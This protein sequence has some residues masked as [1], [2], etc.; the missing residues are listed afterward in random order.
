[1]NI[2]VVDDDA[3]ILQLVKIHLSKEGYKVL[4]AENAEQAFDLLDHMKPD[5]AIVD[6]MMPGMNG[7]E[8]TKIL[9]K[10]YGIP[11]LL[12]TAKGELED[13]E[14]G[15]LAGADDYV[16]R[17]FEPKELLFRVRVILRRSHKEFSSIIQVGNLTVNRTTF[18]ISTGTQSAVIPLKEFE[19]LALLASKAGYV[20]ERGNIMEQIW[21]FDYQGD[22]HTLN[23]HMKRLREKLERLK[24][25]VEIHTIRRIGYKLEVKE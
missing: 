19:L 25:N 15:F 20:V 3:H 16:V 6:V 5:L 2:L 22:D 23:T 4:G 12:L 21:G 14:D 1:M 17:P 24:A 11:V 9:H 10:D 8:M 18:E 7:I 13:K